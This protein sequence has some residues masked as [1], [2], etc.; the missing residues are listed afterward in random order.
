M[1]QKYSVTFPLFRVT[2]RSSLYASFILECCVSILTQRVSLY[3]HLYELSHSSKRDP[4][5][6]TA[7][8]LGLRPLRAP[9]IT[10][11]FLLL[12]DSVHMLSGPE[13][14]RRRRLHY[15]EDGC[16]LGTKYTCYFQHI[17]VIGSR[18]IWAGQ[19]VCMVDLK[20]AYT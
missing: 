1:E 17:S 5:I 10:V 12:L 4:A 6:E 11:F 15:G 8:C 14:F 16:V 18:M 2:G 13:P 20:N 19:V 7:I 9:V 3:K